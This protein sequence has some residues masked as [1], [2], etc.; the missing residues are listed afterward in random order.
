MGAQ[1]TQRGPGLLRGFSY[2]AVRTMPRELLSNGSEDPSLETGTSR[3]L[4]VV[5]E[6]K[7]E[8]HPRSQAEP[9]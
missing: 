8:T 1:G 6:F 9:S 7:F 5:G 2:Q 3:F 4:K